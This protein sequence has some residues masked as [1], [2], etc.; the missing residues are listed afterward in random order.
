MS[1][2]TGKHGEPGATIDEEIWDREYGRRLS[3]P[4]PGIGRVMLYEPSYAPA[5]EATP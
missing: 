2:T 1:S 5:W 3:I 4:V